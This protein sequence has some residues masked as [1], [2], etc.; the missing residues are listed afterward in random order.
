LIQRNSSTTTFR[1]FL[2]A[3]CGGFPDA[4][5]DCPDANGKV[6]PNQYLI[7]SEV[8][9]LYVPT[10]GYVMAKN[11]VNL[12]DVAYTRPRQ[13]TCVFYPAIPAGNPPPV[14]LCDAGRVGQYRPHTTPQ[15]LK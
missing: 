13:S 11:G 12:S 8:N 1:Y 7:S 2:A 14:R 6:I 10:I 5:A 15:S 9:Y 3:G 4:I